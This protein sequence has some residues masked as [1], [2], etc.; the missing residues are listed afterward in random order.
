MVNRRF[1]IFSLLIVL[2]LLLA[3]CSKPEAQKVR[4]QLAWVPTIEYSP[5]YVAQDSGFYADEGLSPEFFNGGFDANGAPIDQIAQVVD[6]K[7]DFG[8]ASADLLLSSRSTGAPIVA[9][10]AF[11]QRSP[12]AFISMADK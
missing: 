8:M 12:I 3:A 11:Y 5:F 9:I 1:Q 10:A 7:A 6:G 2:T 4:V